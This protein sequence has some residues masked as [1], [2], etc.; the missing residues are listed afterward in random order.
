MGIAEYFWMWGLYHSDITNYGS[1]T[2]LLPLEEPTQYMMPI[3]LSGI[4][5]AIIIFLCSIVSM[6]L[7][8]SLKR[9]RK[10]FKN[11]GTKSIGI[12][13]LMLVASIIYIIAISITMT[14]Y[15]EYIIS[16]WYGGYLPPNLI[17]PDFW[18]VY[19]PGFAIIMPFIGAT[20]TIIAGIVSIA[21]KPREDVILVEEKRDFAIKKPIEP[22]NSQVRY[23]PECG[24]KLLYKES[25]FCI[26]CGFK[27][28]S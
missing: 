16:E 14:N 3:F 18:D 19:K 11:V 9:S 4:F 21:V 22:I 1:D 15:F 17:I 10:D 28:Q 6:A 24:Q 12:G 5:S 13:I 27:F 7:A 25:K 23:C 20:F 2:L 26:N 8:N